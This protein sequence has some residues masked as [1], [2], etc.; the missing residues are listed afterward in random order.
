MFEVS[1]T[2]P[3]SI[4]VPGRRTADEMRAAFLH[5]PNAVYLGGS[6]ALAIAGPVG[7]RLGAVLPGL[8]L[9]LFG[10]LMVF[11]YLVAVPIE[12]S[13]TRGVLE[14]VVTEQGP[15]ARSRLGSL[16]LPWQEFS[17]LVA[18][19]SVV[20][21]H[22]RGSARC[23]VLSRRFI[24]PEEIRLMGEWAAARGVDVRRQWQRPWT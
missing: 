24:S 8:A 23:F 15:E 4:R 5:G 12:K 20:L 13:R 18:G 16:P 17:C 1:Q 6:A 7:V 14:W 11:T 10:L 2:A 3:V 19:R 9:T 21:L 22:V